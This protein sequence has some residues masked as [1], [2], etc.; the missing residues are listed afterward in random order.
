MAERALL[1]LTLKTFAGSATCKSTTNHLKF[2]NYE[3]Q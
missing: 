3:N 1:L 2:S